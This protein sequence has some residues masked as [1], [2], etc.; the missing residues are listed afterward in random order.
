MFV[1]SLAISKRLNDEQTSANQYGN[2]AIVYQ[3]QGKLDEAIRVYEKA[4]E[5]MERNNDEAGIAR[6]YGNLGRLYSK[7]GNKTQAREYYLKSL[8]ISNRIKDL[9]T[10]ARQYLALGNLYRDDF[11]DRTQASVQYEKAQALFQM[12]GDADGVQRVASALRGL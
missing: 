5:I 2:L 6:Q 11:R 8:D 7:K 9:H 4:L 3:E 12:V 10:S 1:K